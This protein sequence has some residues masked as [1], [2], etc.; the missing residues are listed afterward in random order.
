MIDKWHTRLEKNV[1]T[2]MKKKVLLEKQLEVLNE[3]LQE[4]I[5]ELKLFERKFYNEDGEPTYG[6]NEDGK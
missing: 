2:M 4:G 3:E 5:I 6:D 1:Q